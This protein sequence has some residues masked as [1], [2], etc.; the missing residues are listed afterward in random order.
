MASILL[1]DD[2]KT[3][4]NG[5]K[6]I[7]GMENIQVSTTTTVSTAKVLLDTEDISLVC[8]DWE[9]PDGTGLDVLAYARKNDIPVVFL[10]GHDEDSYQEQATAQG[11]MQYYIKGQFDYSK[12]IAYIIESANLA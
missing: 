2:D 11:A 3:F 12:L 9:L 7:F 1:V 4:L 6:M 5:L 10:T 8:T